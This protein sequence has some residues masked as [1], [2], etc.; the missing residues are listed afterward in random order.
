MVRYHSFIVY[1]MNFPFLSPLERKNIE[2]DDDSSVIQQFT[3]L[4]LPLDSHSIWIMITLTSERFLLRK[5]NDFSARNDFSIRSVSVL[6]RAIHRARIYVLHMQL[7]GEAIKEWAK[8]SVSRVNKK[9]KS[10]F[11]TGKKLC[12]VHSLRKP[13]YITWA[14]KKESGNEREEERTIK[15]WEVRRLSFHVCS[16]LSEVDYASIRFCDCSL[17]CVVEAS[18]VIWM[19]KQLHSQ[20]QFRFWW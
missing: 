5:A 18:K 1:R 6:T 2:L 12:F 17:L 15:S 16:K 4:C 14:G 20:S 7:E 10:S 19:W 13:A 8:F 3:S 11:W 9:W